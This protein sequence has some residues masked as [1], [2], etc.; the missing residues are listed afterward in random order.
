MTRRTRPGITLDELST[1]SLAQLQEEWRRSVRKPVPRLSISMLRMALGYELQAKARGKLPRAAQ[2]R[3]DRPMEKGCMT[4]LSPGM[5]LI[6]EWQGILHVVTVS[7]DG[8]ILWND[9]EWES[10]SAVA[11]AITGA[12]WSG[13]AFFG[14]NRKKA[15]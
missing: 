1:M 4:V 13:P 7:E 9:R 14:L 8:G 11:R 5:R 15:A 6:R 2:S 10:L 12:R 3:L